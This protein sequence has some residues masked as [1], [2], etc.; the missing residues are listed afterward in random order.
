[1]ATL[2]LRK[3]VC[4]T[5]MLFMPGVVGMCLLTIG[6]II[7]WWYTL[8]L[9]ADV[10]FVLGIWVSMYGLLHGMYI[11]HTWVRHGDVDVP[12]QYP[13]ITALLCV[14]THTAHACTRIWRTLAPP[15]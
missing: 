11:V 9:I 6:Y 10:L 2:L 5:P 14:H 13:L 15:I 3:R 8:L 1:M 7:A 4:G 12:M